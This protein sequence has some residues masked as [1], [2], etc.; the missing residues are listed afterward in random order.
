MSDRQPAPGGTCGA[1][2]E[3]LHK[4]FAAA[5]ESGEALGASLLDPNSVAFKTL[6]GPPLDANIELS[7]TDRWRLAD[8]GAADGHG[9]AR[10]V[11][12]VQSVGER[13]GE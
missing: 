3:P 10:S 8:I 9:N 13:G 6:T 1:R 12:R 7:R 11:V 2:Y 5:F 4:L